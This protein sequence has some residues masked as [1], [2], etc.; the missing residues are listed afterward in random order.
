MRRRSTSKKYLALQEEHYALKEICS[1]QERT[2]EELGGQLSTAKLVAVELREA[3]DNAQQ[4]QQQ[5]DGAATWANDR[6]VS[7]CKSCN[8]EFN[9]TRRKLLRQ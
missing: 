8:R 5:Q 2:L 9:I 7:H 4:Q 3:A 6:L 1:E